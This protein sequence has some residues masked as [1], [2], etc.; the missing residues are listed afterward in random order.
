MYET[1]EHTADVGLRIRAATLDELLAEAAHGLYALIVPDQSSVRLATVY[2]I[3]LA[4]E[5]PDLLLFDWLSELLYVYETRHL[6]LAAFEVHLAETRLTAICR[7]EPIDPARHVL[8]HE[9]KAITYHG[10]K[11]EHLPD[12]SWLAEVIVD[13]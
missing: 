3:E 9:V 13:I 5:A 7:G 8:D 12:G 2:R 4:A 10:L 6:L 11:V 1:F